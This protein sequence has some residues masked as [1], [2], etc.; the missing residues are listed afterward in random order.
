M[1]PTDV[2]QPEANAL[3]RKAWQHLPQALW[4]IP[5]LDHA[6]IQ[7]LSPKWR[8]I[9]DRTQISLEQLHKPSTLLHSLPAQSQAPL[10]QQA[11]L[12]VPKSKAETLLWLSLLTAAGVTTCWAVAHNKGGAKSLPRLIRS[13]TGHSITKV[14]S[15]QHC[16]L[17]R[18]ELQHSSATEAL[19]W[20]HYSLDCGV[21][22]ASLPGVFSHGRLDAGTA[23]LLAHLPAFTGSVL[24]FG[25]GCGVVTVA[26]KAR[27]PAVQITATDIHPLAKLSTQ[28]SLQLNGLQARVLCDIGLPAGASTF[29][30]IVSNPPFH[31]GI[32]THYRSTEQFI[33][34]S[35]KRLTPTGQLWLVVNRFLDYESVLQRCYRQV[36]R[37]ADNTAYK[38]IR[39]SQPNRQA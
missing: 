33:A 12:Y 29:D 9:P 27:N 38:I 21:Q 6:H 11:L 15:G 25:C 1:S 23:L 18:L 20:Q 3:L 30:S 32:H 13:S 10:P 8:L 35:A 39:A 16:L 2:Q 36:D 24:D 37:I 22:I 4:V 31:Q 17:Y 7:P 19:P 5:P 26:I 14:Q 34:H 28:Y